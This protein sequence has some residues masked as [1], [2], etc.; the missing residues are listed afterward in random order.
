MR[1]LA[2][3][4]LCHSDGRRLLV[5]FDFPLPYMMVAQEA[6]TGE[7]DWHLAFELYPLD[8]APGVS[9]G[10]TE[11]MKERRRRPARRPSGKH[12]QPKVAQ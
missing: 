2:R 8:R 1:T 5:L 3:H 9:V 7:A 4:E 6:P 11:L 10:S 12:G